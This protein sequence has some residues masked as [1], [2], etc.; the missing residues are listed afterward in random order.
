MSAAKETEA[1]GG[2]EPDRRVH[3]TETVIQG[4][5]VELDGG[6]SAALKTPARRSR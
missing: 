6:T 2:S 1:E 5:G 3:E 4:L